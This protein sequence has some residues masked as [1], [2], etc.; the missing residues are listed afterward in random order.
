MTKSPLRYDGS[1]HTVTRCQADD[2][3]ECSY[4]GCPQIRDGEPTKSGRHC[5]RDAGADDAGK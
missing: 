2:D 5:P 4:D 3:G 1:T